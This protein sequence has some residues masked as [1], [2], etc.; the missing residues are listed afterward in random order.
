MQVFDVV[1]VGD[2]VLDVFMT[3]GQS[4]YVKYDKESDKLILHAGSKVLIDTAGFTLG[5]NASNVAVGLSR[6][7]FHVSLVAEHGDDEFAQKIRKGLLSENVSLDATKVTPGA[8]STFSAGITIGGERT[9]FIHHVKREHQLSLDNLQAEWVYLTSMGEEWEEMYRKVLEYVKTSG[10]KLAFNPGSAQ[11][12]AGYESFKDVVSMSDILFVNRDEAEEILYGKLRRQ[13]EKES[14]ESL[15]FRVQRMGPKMVVITDGENGSYVLDS[16]N[17]IFHEGIVS[18]KVKIGKT[19]VGDSYASGFL[20]AVM[21][22]K[23]TQTA[24]QWGTHNA[25]AVLEHIGAQTNLLTKDE[26]EKRIERQKVEVEGEK[27]EQKGME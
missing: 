18:G 26:L 7:G 1:C 17:Q 12:K 19:G 23:D 22:G 4:D 20:G 3:A 25:G 2:S 27:L 8:P 10:A 13:E 11:M 21:S 16:A 15:L 6:L 9:L 5:G 14:T 24:M